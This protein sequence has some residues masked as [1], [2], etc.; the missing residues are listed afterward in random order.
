[1]GFKRC[2]AALAPS[3]PSIS[4]V[5]QYTTVT[6]SVLIERLSWNKRGIYVLVAV[7]PNI[8]PAKDH[9][10]DIEARA[11]ASQHQL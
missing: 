5:P 1:M 4:L 11:S 2:L 8:Q 6:P 3:H 7:R 9:C 10:Q